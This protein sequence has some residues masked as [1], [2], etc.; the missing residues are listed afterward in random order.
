MIWNLQTSP[1]FKVISESHSESN[2]LFPPPLCFNDCFHD[3]GHAINELLSG[4][5]RS[6][7]PNLLERILPHMHCSPVI[8]ILLTIFCVK[9]S[10]SFRFLPLFSGTFNRKYSLFFRWTC[11]C[12]R[13]TSFQHVWRISQNHFNYFYLM[14]SAYLLLNKTPTPV[15]M[16]QIMSCN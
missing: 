3:F 13:L 8:S 14:I 11:T 4:V 15:R 7:V 1:L 10:E 2:I 5:D 12:L 9:V 16:T 6:C